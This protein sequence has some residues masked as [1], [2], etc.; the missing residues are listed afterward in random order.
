MSGAHAAAAKVKDPN[1]YLQDA[2]R[3]RRPGIVPKVVS[4]A[5]VQVNFPFCRIFEM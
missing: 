2:G 3:Y 5:H 1:D 4:E